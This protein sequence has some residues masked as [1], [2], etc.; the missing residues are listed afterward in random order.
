MLYVT[1]AWRTVS[2]ALLTPDHHYCRTES[3][4]SRYNQ[5]FV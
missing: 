2:A 1:E 5:E 4:A 3:D